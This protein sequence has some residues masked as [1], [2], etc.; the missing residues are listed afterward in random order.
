MSGLR[1]G[2]HR[3][4]GWVSKAIKW[5][6]RSDY[7]H[8]S[9]VLPDNTVLESM[10]GRG[11]VKYRSVQGCAEVVDLFSVTALARVHND[12]LQFALEQLGKPYDYTMVARFISRRP[13]NRAESGKWFCSE[14]VFAAFAH[15]GLLLLRDTQAWEVSPELLSKSPYLV[16]AGTNRKAIK[17]AA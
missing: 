9:L 16:E 12:A 15:A 10:Q 6:T 5:Q 8:A 14:L 7:S 2:L 17:E 13:A 1:I 4:D 11:V 3:A